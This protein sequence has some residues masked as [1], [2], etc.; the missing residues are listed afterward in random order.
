[1]AAAVFVTGCGQTS[2]N[3]P[4]DSAGVNA[5]P[6]PQFVPTAFADEAT[7]AKDLFTVNCQICHKENGKGGRTTVEGKSLN[8][9]DLT[10][11][12]FKKATDEKLFEYIAEGVPDEGMPA[13][14]RKMS[15]EQLRFIVKHLRNLQAK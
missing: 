10:E 12:K 7:V 8:P 11:D 2:T 4:L 6:T 14:K 13:F 5:R 15:A 9:D 1:M 3:T